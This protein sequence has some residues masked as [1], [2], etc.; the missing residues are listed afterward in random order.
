MKNLEYEELLA[1]IIPLDLATLT[2]LEADLTRIVTQRQI[3]RSSRK[4]SLMELAAQA[5]ESLKDLDQ[6]DYWAEREKEL[7]D[8]RNSWADKEASIDRRG[9]S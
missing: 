4:H 9:R 5:A 1:R 7:A 8:S 2:R 3:E 6:A